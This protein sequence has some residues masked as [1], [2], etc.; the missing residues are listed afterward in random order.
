MK[1]LFIIIAI[2]MI[3]G[4]GFNGSGDDNIED[5]SIIPSEPEHVDVSSIPGNDQSGNEG[6]E[7]E[8][9]GLIGDQEIDDQERADLEEAEL[10]GWIALDEVVQHDTQND[11]WVMLYGQV[12]D[13]TRYIT[14]HP[15]DMAIL[16]ACGQ[17][18]EA[19]FMIQPADF[20]TEELLNEYYIGDLWH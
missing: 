4:C 18:T 16:Q 8:P 12:F 3:S 7:G 1:K 14:S 20:I 5:Q 6:A 19:L 11:C 17:D 9:A 10:A 2:L 13:V 15:E